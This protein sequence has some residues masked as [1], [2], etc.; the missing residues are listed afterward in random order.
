MQVKVAAVSPRCYRGES[1][2][3]NVAR[4]LTAIDEAADQGAQIV[5]FPEGYPGPYN[6]PVTYSA[7]EPLADKAR[8]RGVHVIAGMVER[9]ERYAPR[10]VYHLA[11][12]LIGPRGE[13]T[14]TYR[15]VLPNPKEMNQ[16]LMGG[17]VIAAG[18]D[19]QVF[20]TT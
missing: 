4:A 16:F 19:L 9:A 15:R 14:G 3:D 8:Q 20:E 10:P 17:K 5:C 1:E 11:L 13:L 6:G 18:D 2:G 12:K 7:V